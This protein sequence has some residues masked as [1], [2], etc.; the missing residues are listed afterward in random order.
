ML[1]AIARHLIS[2]R[3]WQSL[4]RAGRRC[5]QPIDALYCSLRGVKYNHGW[6]LHGWPVFR[7]SSSATLT[8]GRRWKA[9]SSFAAN[10]I[11]VLQPVYLNVSKGATLTIGDDVGMSGCSVACKQEIRIGNRVLIGTGVVITDND[12]HPIHPDFRFDDSKIAKAAVRIEDDVFIGARA[13]ILKGVTVGKGAVVG[14]CAVVTKN[15]PE[16]SI[17]AGNPAQVVGSSL[18]KRGKNAV[19]APTPFDLEALDRVQS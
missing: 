9:I 16:Y 6:E 1:K 17:V 8:I 5:H 11:G 13:F 12:A 10:T 15:V 14:A 2:P 4:I 18:G 3:L 7:K 19:G